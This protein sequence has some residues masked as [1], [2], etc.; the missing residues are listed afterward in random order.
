[1]QHDLKCHPQ[2]FDALADGSKTFEIRFND[3][4]YEVGDTLLLRRYD[5]QTGYTGESLTRRVTYVLSS[6]VALTPG[7]V[8]MGLA[9]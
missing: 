1:M 9:E 8:A 5:P 7:Y 4:G 6:Y 2:Y 3:R